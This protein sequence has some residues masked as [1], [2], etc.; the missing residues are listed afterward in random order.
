MMIEQAKGAKGLSATPYFYAL[1]P[2]DHGDLSFF[3]SPHPQ[4][5]FKL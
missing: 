5:K 1:S 3:G 2:D 4:R